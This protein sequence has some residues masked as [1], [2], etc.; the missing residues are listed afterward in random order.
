MDKAKR[1]LVVERGTRI[2]RTYDCMYEAL[3]KT[4]EMRET[5]THE[6]VDLYVLADPDPRP[7]R[8][9]N[10]MSN[11][12]LADQMLRYGGNPPEEE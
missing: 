7:V 9:R 2:T 3:N 4:A 12:E 1:F 8:K 10:E 5:P 11:Q 6:R